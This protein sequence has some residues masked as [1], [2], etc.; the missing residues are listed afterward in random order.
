MIRGERVVH[1]TPT[2]FL[3]RKWG[4]RFAKRMANRSPRGPQSFS[5]CSSCSHLSMS[6]P[7]LHCCTRTETSRL[8][9]ER[10][11]TFPSVL[12]SYV[13]YVSAFETMQKVPVSTSRLETI[14]NSPEAKRRKL[15]SS[16]V[17]ARFDSGYRV[18]LFDNKKIR[19]RNEAKKL[20]VQRNERT[21]SS[22]SK[23]VY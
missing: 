5:P 12:S 19:I 13:S 6:S 17:I 2:S 7:K 21:S 4:E 23:S 16:E 9:K 20:K 14:E 8:R 11:E 15:L 10:K 18:I 22:S 1:L 3:T